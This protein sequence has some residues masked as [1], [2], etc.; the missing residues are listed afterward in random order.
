MKEERRKE[1]RKK[2]GRK[3]E[4][5]IVPHLVPSESPYHPRLC[6]HIRTQTPAQCFNHGKSRARLLSLLSS[7]FGP[8]RESRLLS[9]CSQ[10]CKNPSQSCWWVCSITSLDV[11]T[12]FWVGDAHLLYRVTTK[13]VEKEMGINKVRGCR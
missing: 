6:P 2:E 8:T 5:R 4:T 7:P 1:R 11:Q 3:K 10:G 13:S 9:P 12:L